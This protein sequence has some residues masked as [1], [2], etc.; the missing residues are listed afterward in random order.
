MRNFQGIIFIW[1][2]MYGQI[3]I[4]VPLNKKVHINIYLLKK[5]KKNFQNAPWKSFFKKLYRKYFSN[6]FVGDFVI[7]FTF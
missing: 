3:C 5:D 4:S 7:P 6:T 1:I 2:W